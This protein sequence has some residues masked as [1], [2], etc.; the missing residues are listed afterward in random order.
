MPPRRPPRSAILPIPYAFAV[1]GAFA[2]SLFLVIVALTNVYT[3][4]LL[5]RGAVATGAVDYEGLSHAVG[6][7]LLKVRIRQAGGEFRLRKGSAAALE[8]E[9]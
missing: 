8:T 9:L 5:L 3:C 7:F 4:R 6:G 2:A 1:T